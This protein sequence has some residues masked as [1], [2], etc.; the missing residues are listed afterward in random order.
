MTAGVDAASA[1]AQAALARFDGVVLSALRDTDSALTSYARDLQ[2]DRDL[3][4]AQALAVEG[5]REAERLYHGGK[6]DFISFLDAQWTLDSANH[7][8]ASSHAQLATDQ[9][10]I[11]L[12]LGGGWK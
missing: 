10:D 3:A 8:L 7:A 2:R 11:F 5:E 4:V 9:V 6:F 1:S 12:A